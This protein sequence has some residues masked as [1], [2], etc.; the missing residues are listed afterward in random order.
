MKRQACQNLG[1]T[2]TIV[3][4]GEITALNDYIRKEEMFKNNYLFT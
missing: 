3:V 4:R 1:V 2:A